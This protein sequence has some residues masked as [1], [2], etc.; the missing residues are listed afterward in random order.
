MANLKRK[1]F[2]K[3]RSYPVVRWVLDLPV[4]II[5]K[6]PIISHFYFLFQKYIAKTGT[7]TNQYIKNDVMLYPIHF[8]YPV[9]DFKRLKETDAF[10]KINRLDGIRFDS[11]EHLSFLY[12]ISKDYGNECNFPSKR[13]ENEIEFTTENDG[14]S[15]GCASLLHCMIREFKPRRIVEVGAGNSSK[16][17][18]NAVQK[19]FQDGFETLYYSIDPYPHDFLRR[20]PQLSKLI[21]KRVEDLDTAFF[22]QLEK[23]DIL[24]IDSSH[25]VV[26][27]ND[28]T[29]LI[30]EV[31]PIL[32]SG[33]FVHFH[34]I[35]LPYQYPKAYYVNESFRTCWNEQFLLQAFLCMNPS[36]S[37]KLPANYLYKHFPNEFRKAFIYNDPDIHTLTSGSFWIQ[38]ENNS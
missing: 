27:G 23:N 12:E 38:R 4:H 10:N 17:I 19:N 24:F 21:E 35:N 37:I 7:G 31:L 3:L 18:N 8:Y 13:S 28:V 1:I 6:L 25:Q 15:F 26:L 2:Y 34:D 11:N 32:K 33:V 20:L 22:Q 30:L 29:Y 5:T 14:F 36:Y 9:P 16:V